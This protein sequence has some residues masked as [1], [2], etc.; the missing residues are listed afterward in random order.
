MRLLDL[1]VILVY[2]VAI[3]AVGLRLS[4][5]QASATA[6]F[7]GERDLP[8]W[9]VCFSVVATE[10]STLTVIS[11]PGV[12]Y[13]GA[14]GFVELSIGYLLGRS[15]VAFMLLP[16]YMRGGFVSAYQYLGQRFGGGLQG[17]AAVTFLGTRL[18]AEGV[19][20]F[21]SAIPIKLL[22]DAI[23]LPTGY[24]AIIAGLSLVTVLIPTPAASGR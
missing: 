17:L 7:V 23:G 2:L 18:L 13:L 20:L 10:T 6:Y 14:F 4:G 24:V 9:A 11:V 3:A 1:L 5:R 21:A 12:A 15:L 19:R 16:L 8:W 22:L